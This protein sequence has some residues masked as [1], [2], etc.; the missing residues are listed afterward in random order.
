MSEQHFREKK[1]LERTAIRIFLQRHNERYEPA[2]R[3]LYQQERPD[4]VLENTKTRGK[5]GL[6]I[7]HLF[8]DEY[9]AKMVLGRQATMQCEI[10]GL[11]KLIGELNERIRVKEGKFAAYSHDYPL[12]L[13][14]RNA[15]PAFRLTDILE[16]KELICK[17]AGLF[18]HIWFLSR[19]GGDEW[20]LAELH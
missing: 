8:Y 17:S 18:E 5:I 6:E 13:L 12:S 2:M 7:T 4:A 19:D 1:L 9:E 10:G 3:L 20:L 14:I 15:S 16:R 11:D